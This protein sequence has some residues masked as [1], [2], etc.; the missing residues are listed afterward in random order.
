MNNFENKKNST[1]AGITV[2]VCGLLFLLLTLI[3]WQTPIPPPIPT[4][5]GIEVNFGNS[6]TGFGEQPVQSS[7]TSAAGETTPLPTTQAE[8]STEANLPETGDEPVLVKDT[9][10]KTTP[11]P[12]AEPKPTVVKPIAPKAT[13]GKIATGNGTAKSL[14]DSYSNA[15]SQGIAGGT[16]DQGKPNGSLSSN[17]YTGSGGTGMGISIRS[18]LDGRRIQRL[19]KFEEEFSENA[20]VAVDIEVNAAGKVTKATVNPRGTTTSSANIKKIALEKAYQI[21]LNDGA[22]ETQV[23]TLVFEFKLRG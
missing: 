7:T 4:D 11:T 1:A 5:E 22:E 6:E 21:K 15:T 8:P 18:G 14:E 16:G 17:N 20:K 9:K 2:T 12:K 23:G 3:S 13:L 10:T 19:P